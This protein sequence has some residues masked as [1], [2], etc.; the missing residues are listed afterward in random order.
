MVPTIAK[1]TKVVVTTFNQIGQILRDRRNK[2]VTT[3]AAQIG[4]PRFN[5]TTKA[6]VTKLNWT[7]EGMIA[8]AA[9]RVAGRHRMTVRRDSEARLNLLTIPGDVQCSDDP[10]VCLV[11]RNCSSD[12]EI[13]FFIL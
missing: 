2:L 8:R 9:K 10:M 3:A 11:S 12:I 1:K 13:E 5:T 4:T 6:I 7:V